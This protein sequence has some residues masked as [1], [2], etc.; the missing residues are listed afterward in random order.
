MNRRDLFKYV[1]AAGSALLLPELIPKPVTYFLAPRGG[2]GAQRLRIRKCQQY[3]INDELQWR[4]DAT[5]VRPDGEH[6]QFHVDATGEADEPALHCLLDRFEMDG[7]TPNSD[8]FR[9][10]LPRTSLHASYIYADQLHRM[11]VLD[12]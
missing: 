4:Y 9:L 5:W 2:W 12:L 10:E 6:V 7:G 11:R 1:A 8:H 3:S